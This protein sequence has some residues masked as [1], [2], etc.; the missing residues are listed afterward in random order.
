MGGWVVGSLDAFMC[1]FQGAWGDDWC[2]L[3]LS[4]G[5]VSDCGLFLS[6]GGL[7]SLLVQ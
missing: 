6:A 3:W 2:E 1:F 5:R 7:I 4:V